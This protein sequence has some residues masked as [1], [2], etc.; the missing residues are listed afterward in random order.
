MVY[1][2]FFIVYALFQNNYEFIL[3]SLIILLLLLTT[4]NIYRK[5]ELSN[6]IVVSLSLFGLLHLAG[7]NLTWAGT[8]L[9]DLEYIGGA[10]H[11][12]NIVHAIGVF[13]TTL[14]LY[15][16]I[17]PFID[18]RIRERY[19]VFYL[20]LVLM[21]LGVGAVNEMIELSAVVFLGAGASVGDYLNNALDLVFNA[22][23]SIMAIFVIHRYI[24]HK[25]DIKL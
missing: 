4:I 5:V 16:L 13:L 24:R 8:R 9:Y 14:I 2:I 10:L 18:K 6:W 19:G 23:G 17:Y 21:A 25:L 1:T 12:D 20:L 15:N 7:G 3:Y 11:F 22:A